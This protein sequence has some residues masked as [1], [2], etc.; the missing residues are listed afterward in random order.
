MAACVGG[1]DVVFIWPT[2]GKRKL[3]SDGWVLSCP[4]GFPNEIFILSRWLTPER[5]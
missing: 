5:P 4:S 2:N 1:E 3:V